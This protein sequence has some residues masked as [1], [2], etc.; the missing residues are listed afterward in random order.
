MLDQSSPHIHELRL[1]RSNGDLHPTAVESHLQADGRVKNGTYT[2]QSDATGGHRTFKISTVQNPGSGLHGKRIVSLLTGPDNTSDYQGFAFVEDD[3]SMRVWGRF[4]GSANETYGT[5]LMAI[6]VRGR[7]QEDGTVRAD[8][9]KACVLFKSACRVCNR[10][11]TDPESIRTGIGP[12]CAGRA[13][14]A[15]AA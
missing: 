7:V 12:I 8:P 6:L 14:G 3:N 5:I 9:L 1:D 4:R 15:S 13:E 11:L 10:P 2:V